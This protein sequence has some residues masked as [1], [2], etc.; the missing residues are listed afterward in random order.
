MDAD[1]TARAATR[2]NPHRSTADLVLLLASVASLIAVVGVLAGAK[3]APG[4]AK[5]WLAVLALVSVTASWFVVHTLFT[6]R[7]AELY[8]TGPDGGVSFNQKERPRYVEFAYLA[9]T[10]GMTFQVSD[11]DIQTGVMRVTV[12]RHSLLSYLFGAVVLASTVNLLG[13]LASGGG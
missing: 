6:L 7:Y 9:F 4:A 8:Y 10:V 13:G 11:T 12:L 1:A 3:S 5:D 2:Q